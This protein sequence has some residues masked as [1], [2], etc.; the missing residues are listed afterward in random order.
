M[1]NS[2]GGEA[3]TQKAGLQPSQVDLGQALFRV[4]H[5]F[6]QHPHA[7]DQQMQVRHDVAQS[8]GECLQLAFVGD[9]QITPVQAFGVL[10]GQALQLGR[11][12]G[13][14]R[15]SPYAGYLRVRQQGRA[16]GQAD[17]TAGAADQ[18]FDWFGMLLPPGHAGCSSVLG[19]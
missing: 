2:R 5:A 13:V 3:V 6:L 18:C 14:A 8:G 9:I 12:P 7:I 1:S 15:H 17:T 10:A 11:L 16:Q 4:Y 19:A